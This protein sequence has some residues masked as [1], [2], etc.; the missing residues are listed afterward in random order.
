MTTRDERLAR[1]KETA[2]KNSVGC[3]NTLWLVLEE[4]EKDERG[5]RGYCYRVD[6]RLWG[7]TSPIPVNA[8]ASYRDGE[9]WD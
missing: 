2:R 4:V 7:S 5:V 6:W 3:K 8:V 9:S 1:A